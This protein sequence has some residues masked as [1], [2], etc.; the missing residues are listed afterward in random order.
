MK[1]GMDA[2]ASIPPGYTAA[3]LRAARRALL[4]ADRIV[5]ATLMGHR[6][7]SAMFAC[8]NVRFDFHDSSWCDVLSHCYLP[9][10]AGKWGDVAGVRCYGSTRDVDGSSIS[11]RGFDAHGTRA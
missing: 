11:T 1:R 4:V 9:T 10:H 5:V 7:V 2:R 6:I 8:T 3:L